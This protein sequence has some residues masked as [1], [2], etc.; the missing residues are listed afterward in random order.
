MKRHIGFIIFFTMV[1]SIFLGRLMVMKAA[2]I[3]GD[4][5]TQFYPWSKI[6]S[7]TIKALHF[8]FWSRYFHSGFPLMAEG[9]IG[10]YYPLNIIIFFLLPFKLAYNYSVVLHFILAG[11]FTYLYARKIGAGQ[12]GGALAVLTFCFGSAYAGCFYNIATLRTL[13][14]FPLVLLLMERFLESNLN[15]LSPK[16]ERASAKGL[17]YILICGIIS[18]MQFLAGFLQMAAYSFIFYIIYLL[19]GI[20]LKRVEAGKA[21][22][23]V[24]LFAMVSVMV[25][26]PQVLL[27]YDL[28]QASGRATASLGFALWNSFPPP[29]FLTLFFPRWMGFI[30]H[31]LF[32]GTL[33]VMFLIYAIINAKNSPQLRPLILVGVIAVFAALGRYNPLYVAILKTTRFY[34]FRNP[35]KLL[36]FGLFAGSVLSGFG[37][38]KFFNQPDTRLIR[39]TARIFS[40]ISALFILMFF[41]FRLFIQLF[42]S[43]I[44]LWLQDYVLKH[45]LGR[46]YHRYDLQTYMDKINNIY[47]SLENGTNLSDIYVFVSMVMAVIGLATA[48]F[49]FIKPNKTRFLRWPVLGIIFLDIFAYSFY[50]TGFRGNIKPFEYLRPTHT[51]ILEILRSDQ[52]LFRILPFDLQSKELPYWVRP[53]ANILYGLDSIAAYTPLVEKGYQERLSSL[54]VV[55]DALG[56]LSPSD[57][58]LLKKHQLLRLLNVKYIVSSRELSYGFLKKVISENGL[59]LYRLNGYLPR[60]FFTSKIDG[61]IRAQPVKELKVMEYQSGLIRL[62]VATDR[63]GFLVFSEN[64]Y[65][66]WRAYIDGKPAEIIPAKKIV[67]AIKI[68]KGSYRVVFSF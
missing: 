65:P 43:R 16:G 2:F 11:I 5:L 26:L 41:I 22:G 10:G 47:L 14:W 33:T 35:S 32:I 7:E 42:K 46:P 28:A 53:N 24:F 67:Q 58:A 51:R 8:P 13:V 27:T 57:K 36:F 49:I 66:G 6:Y 61:E 56:L 45:I 9:Q 68:G 3:D 12:W 31:Q 29:C 4:Y 55:D 20:K 54:E 52:E 40:V 18:G 15:S 23:G 25:A 60:A 21:G 62:E 64:Y 1:I 63:G 37:F 50:G 30:G 48:I 19:Y 34:S 17:S 59:F 38:S 44:V 39:S